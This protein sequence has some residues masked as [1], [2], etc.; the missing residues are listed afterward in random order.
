MIV[1]N[2]KC[3]NDHTFEVWFRNSTDYTDQVAAKEVQCP[4]CESTSVGKALMAP[5]I[6]A[7]KSGKQPYVQAA[8]QMHQMMREMHK[9]ITENCDYVGDTFAK[10]ARAIHEGSAE[11]RGIYGEATAEEASELIEDGIEV[12]AIP[13]LPKSDA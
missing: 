8:S 6:G 4:M 12:A 11:E 10:E 2:L 7:R 5:N 3:Q 13:T 9:R 1:Y